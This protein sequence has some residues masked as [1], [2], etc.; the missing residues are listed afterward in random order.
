MVNNNYRIKKSFGR[1]VHIYKLFTNLL[2]FHQFRAI[3]S[4]NKIQKGGRLMKRLSIYYRHKTIFTK[5]RSV[6][7]MGLSYFAL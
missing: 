4:N 3:I 7:K 1:I 6:M 5:K 2:T